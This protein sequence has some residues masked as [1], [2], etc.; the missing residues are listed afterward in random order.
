[1]VTGDA[2]VSNGGSIVI[3]E[4]GL[5]VAMSTAAKAITVVAATKRSMFFHRSAIQL[6]TR[7]PAMPDGG[8]MADD[9]LMI[10]DPV[11]GIAYEFV[12][13]RGKR[14]VRYEVNLAWGVKMVAPRHSG[15]LIGA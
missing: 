9:V 1:V 13:Y 12:V 10:T 2:D 6:L 4:P 3:A 7:A 15:L 5:R 11:T 8:D 14:Q